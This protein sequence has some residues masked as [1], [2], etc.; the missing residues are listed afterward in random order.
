MS[1]NIAPD[2]IGSVPESAVKLGHILEAPHFE[3]HLN[4][5]DV[6]AF[7]FTIDSTH[8]DWNLNKSGIPLLNILN[9]DIIDFEVSWIELSYE[10]LG[11]TP[12]RRVK[13][14][15]YN[16]TKEIVFYIE[17]VRISHLGSSYPWYIRI[18]P[19]TKTWATIGNVYRYVIKI[20]YTNETLDWSGP[21]DPPSG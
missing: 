2:G 19:D 4:G 13:L 8:P 12:T 18:D 16:V 11:E 9:T 10:G 5:Q 17:G 21:Q 7:T 6:Y 20:Y 14:P 15:Q 3:G 1:Y